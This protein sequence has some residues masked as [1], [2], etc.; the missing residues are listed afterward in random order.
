GPASAA[1]QQIHAENVRID[2]IPHPDSYSKAAVQIW[3]SH[4][5]VELGSPF[6]IHWNSTGGIPIVRSNP[7]QSPASVDGVF[8]N[9]TNGE[10][11]FAKRVPGIY[12]Y[13][14]QMGSLM[15]EVVVRVLG[16]QTAPPAP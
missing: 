16:T 2:V 4:S 6:S 1:G 10:I 9:Q 14:I 13:S 3:A 7:G 11:S 15:Q 8:S 5:E 12:R